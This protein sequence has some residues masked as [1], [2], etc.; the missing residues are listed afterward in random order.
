M[1]GERE[2][3]REGGNEKEKEKE[4]KRSSRGPTDTVRH[5]KASSL[6]CEI[7]V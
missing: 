5:S 1:K 7:P 6:A 3:K 2:S 4:K